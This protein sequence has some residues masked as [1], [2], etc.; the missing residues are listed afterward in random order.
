MINANN[1]FTGANSVDVWQNEWGCSGFPPIETDGG[2]GTA[3]GHWDEEIFGNE[4]MTGF[5]NSGANPISRVTIGAM[6]DMG[7]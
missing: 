5:L 7:Y 3:G 6:E 4:I 2:A 1:D